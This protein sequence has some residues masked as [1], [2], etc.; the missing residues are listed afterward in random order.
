MIQTAI[1]TFF[2]LTQPSTPPSEEKKAGSVSLGVEHVQK[3]IP[4]ILIVTLDKK[5]DQGR[6]SF[7][8]SGK[9][10]DLLI[11]LQELLNQSSVQSVGYDL[12]FFGPPNPKLDAGR[13][14]LFEKFK[15]SKIPIVLADVTRQDRENVKEIFGLESKVSSGTCLMEP[16]DRENIPNAENPIERVKGNK[17]NK[18]KLQR[19][20]AAKMLGSVDVDELQLGFAEES[21]FN[22]MEISE[23]LKL[24][25]TQQ[26][27]ILEERHV[28]VGVDY[29]DLDIIEQAGTGKRMNGVFVHAYALAT[30]LAQQELSKQTQNSSK[31]IELKDLTLAP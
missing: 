7:K 22:K 26:K 11:K 15:A 3:Q 5:T 20:L 4:K 6:E 18:D 12:Y 28:L 27:K 9:H 25:A 31:K 13:P 17:W 23:L 1:F 8:E 2:V 30:L 16:I 24:D 21:L 10:I 29:D 14:L 19:S